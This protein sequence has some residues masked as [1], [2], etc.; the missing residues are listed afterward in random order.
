MA[1]NF[2]PVWLLQIAPLAA[3]ERS[4][5][6]T[7]LCNPASLRVL[8]IKTHAVPV[9]PKA[10]DAADQ[11]AGHQPVRLHSYDGRSHL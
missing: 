3:G 4:N 7:P 6:V 10:P 9:P 8:L 11:P 2:L 1:T 5:A